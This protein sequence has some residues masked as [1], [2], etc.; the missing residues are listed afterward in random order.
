MKEPDFFLRVNSD[1]LPGLAMESGWP[2]SWQSLS[3]DMNLLL[4]GGDGDIGAVVLLKWQ[5]LSGTRYVR[6]FVELYVRDRNGMPIRRQQEVC[7]RSLV[8][9]TDSPTEFRLFFPL[10]KTPLLSDWNLH[11]M[12]S[13]AGILKK[14]RHAQALPIP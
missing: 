3:D 1:R 9:L 6:G 8:Y 5:I 7:S 14:I 2:E 4:V 13:S 11:A 10:P 12:K